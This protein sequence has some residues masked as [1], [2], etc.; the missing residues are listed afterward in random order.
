MHPKKLLAYTVIIAVLILCAFFW[1]GKR[2]AREL[3]RAP[4]DAPVPAPFRQ[5]P[6]QYKK[7]LPGKMG[8]LTASEL[9]WVLRERLSL[10]LMLEL[11]GGRSGVAAYNER[12]DL[13][14]ELAGQFE[15]MESDM[16]AAL[17]L[18]ESDREAIASRA[19]DDALAG[20]NEIWRA[21]QFLR[22]RGL[23]LA[24]PTGTMN[25][26]TE[27]AVKMYQLQRNEP[28]TGVVSIKLLDTLKADYLRERSGKEILF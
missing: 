28:Q 3:A 24:N 19:V 15:Y 22:L 6:E 9:A 18:V 20:E 2:A 7:P 11:A 16:N 17:K 21:Q 10:D 14:N 27:Y 8:N 25:R 23:Y 12:R 1:Q 13:F 4:E 26:D 5:Q